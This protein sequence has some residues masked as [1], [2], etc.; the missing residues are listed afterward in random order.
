M[1][2]IHVSVLGNE[3]ITFLAPRPDGWYIDG[4][5]GGGGHSWSLLQASSATET[6]DLGGRVLSLDADPHAVARVHE[7]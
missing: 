1:T 7:R 2:T 6:R 4:T 5:A 3:I